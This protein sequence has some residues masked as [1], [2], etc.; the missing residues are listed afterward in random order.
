MLRDVRK[1][2]D[3]IAIDSEHRTTLYKMSR[4][5]YL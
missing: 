5:K 3:L 4:V 2:Q 1:G